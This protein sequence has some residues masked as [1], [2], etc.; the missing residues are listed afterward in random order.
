M[1]FADELNANA[2]ARPPA[3]AIRVH[4]SRQARKRTEV[5]GEPVVW[6][7]EFRD[8]A[9]VSFQASTFADSEVVQDLGAIGDFEDVWSSANRKER[10]IRVEIVGGVEY[11]LGTRTLDDCKAEFGDRFERRFPRHDRM[12][13]PRRLGRTYGCMEKDLV[14]PFEQDFEWW[15]ILLLMA[16]RYCR[17]S[18][19]IIAPAGYRVP[20]QVATHSAAAGKTA[21]VVDFNQVAGPD[22]GLISHEY[23]FEMPKT[24]DEVDLRARYQNVMRNYLPL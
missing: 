1:H 22:L 19:L 12:E 7:R 5:A 11:A 8:S 14:E 2:H 16:F 9:E 23:Q 6:F 20:W 15:E 21:T 18:I 17:T 10:C 13:H 24:K 3:D 4:V